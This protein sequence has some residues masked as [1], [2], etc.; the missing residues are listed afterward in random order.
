MVSRRSH[1]PGDPNQY[2]VLFI[3]E[4]R[5]RQYNKD[6]ESHKPSSMII[7]IHLTPKPNSKV[8][9]VNIRASLDWCY[10][11][12]M[13]S[14]DKCGS[15]GL[16]YDCLQWCYDMHGPCPQVTASNDWYSLNGCRWHLHNCP[17]CWHRAYY[18]Y[19]CIVHSLST[20]LRFITVST[21][22]TFSNVSCF[23]R[24]FAGARTSCR[25]P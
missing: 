22:V 13:S 10:A 16:D 7:K 2:D 4:A 21:L 15:D 17:Y 14:N 8:H 20:L 23:N 1:V 19:S 9:P 25:S 5:W 24:I 12:V 11:L 18:A 3:E 6:Y